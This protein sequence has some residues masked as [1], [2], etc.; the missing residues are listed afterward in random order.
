MQH[1]RHMAKAPLSTPAHLRAALARPA[2]DPPTRDDGACYVCL[3][4]RSELA[5]KHDDP[6]C[7]ATCTREHYGAQLAD[8]HAGPLAA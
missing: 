7:S 8:V 4:E 2:G 3:G 1:D 6:F 5:Q